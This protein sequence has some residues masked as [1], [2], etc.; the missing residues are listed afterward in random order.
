METIVGDLRR[1]VV[2]RRISFVWSDLPKNKLPDLTK[3]RGVKISGIERRG[4]N[5]LFYLEGG[6]NNLLLV[7]HPRMTGHFLLGRW[8]I[9][10][11]AKQRIEPVS[12]NGPLAEKINSYIHLILAFTDGEMLGLSDVR[13]FSKVLFGGAEGLKD[14]FKKLGP[15]ALSSELTF[16]KFRERIAKNRPIKSVLLDQALVAGVGNIYSDEILWLAKIDPRRPASGLKRK[17]QQRIYSAMRSVLRQAVKSRGTS[18][19]DFRDLR[20]EKGGYGKKRLVYGLAGTP[21]Q[22]CRTPIVAIKISGRTSS[23]CPNCQRE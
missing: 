23:F 16:E 4:K 5:I 10:K 21:C 1:S 17:E 8:E 22:R 7:V 20:G 14:Y 11:N 6:R 3:L 2:G 12:G 18:F 19:S 15:D 13:K 9:P